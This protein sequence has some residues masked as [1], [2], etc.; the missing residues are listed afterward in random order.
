LIIDSKLDLA[1]IQS[2]AR[3]YPC[4]AKILEGLR[5][6]RLSSVTDLRR[7]ET[8]PYALLASAADRRSVLLVADKLNPT[9]PD[10]W[11]TL[12][13]IAAWGSY[14]VVQ[15][16]DCAE[17]GTSCIVFA[18]VFDRLTVIETV[19]AFALQWWA[20]LHRRKVSRILMPDYDLVT[21]D[22]GRVQ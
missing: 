7:E 11:R 16:A 13:A 3:G 22:T 4:R 15:T 18:D 2:V 8:S 14:A 19:E 17:A 6:R 12:D 1:I 9:G 5:D 21:A 20:A 10:G